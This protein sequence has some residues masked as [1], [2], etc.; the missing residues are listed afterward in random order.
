[1][2]KLKAIFLPDLAHDSSKSYTFEYD[3]EAN[4]FFMVSDKEI[5]YD[6]IFLIEMTD[7][8][9]FETELVSDGFIEGVE[10]EI[11]KG[12]VKI[13]PSNELEEYLIKFNKR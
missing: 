11:F 6:P 2:K 3:K 8:L 1:M 10:D 4:Q 12:K 5:A 9:I 7:W 13:I